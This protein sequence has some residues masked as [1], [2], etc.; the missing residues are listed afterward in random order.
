MSNIRTDPFSL[1]ISPATYQ[2]TPC[3]F[4]TLFREHKTDA[5]DH[6]AVLT[7]SSYVTPR[8]ETLTESVYTSLTLASDNG[9]SEEM[10]ECVLEDGRYVITETRSGLEGPVETNVP[11]TFERD[12][13]LLHDAGCEVVVAQK[14]AGQGLFQA[15][16]ECAQV[17]PGVTPVQTP[18]DGRG[19]VGK[20][21]PLTLVRVCVEKQEVETMFTAGPGHRGSLQ[22]AGVSG[23]ASIARE[24]LISTEFDASF[25]AIVHKAISLSDGL[26]QTTSE[27]WEV[28]AKLTHKGAYVRVSGNG[29]LYATDWYAERA[30]GAKLAIEA[31]SS[32]TSEEVEF[33]GNVELI[34]EFKQR[35]KLHEEYVSKHPALHEILADY[36]QLVL[37]R[38]PATVYEFSKGCLTKP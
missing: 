34:S 26:S 22:H 33:G 23:R 24:A 7:V 6:H 15:S 3:Y 1:D 31:S 2:K 29:G 37:H 19:G 4:I 12:Q 9:T 11:S 8:L 16:Y 36:L 21:E 28:E 25:N 35:K 27:G 10:P 18:G 5:D 14:F 20:V 17:S 38:K 13:L 30:G 32:D